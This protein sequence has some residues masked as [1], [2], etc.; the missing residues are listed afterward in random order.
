MKYVNLLI[1]PASSLCN[2]RCG[3][4]F[5]HSQATER[6]AF[7]S[8]HRFLVG[9]SLDGDKQIHDELRKDASGIGT[10]DRVMERIDRLCKYSVEFNVLC[11]VR[12]ETARRAKD[13]LSGFREENTG[14]S[15]RAAGNAGAPSSAKAAAC[16][17][18]S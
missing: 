8:E 11:V 13:A 3:Y 16:A 1:K 12:N 9:I 7:L 2:M 4:C 10:F 17:T 6:T 14:H 18:G 5:Y 15:P